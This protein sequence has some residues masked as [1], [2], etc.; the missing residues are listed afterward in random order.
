VPMSEDLTRPNLMPC[1]PWR[2][3]GRSSWRARLHQTRDR[4]RLRSASGGGG[5]GMALA[6]D[7]GWLDQRRTSG[8]RINPG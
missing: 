5:H 6:A 4:P 3:S 7:I 2:C 8:L 1:G